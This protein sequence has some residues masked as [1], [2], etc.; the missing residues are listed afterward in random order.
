[1]IEKSSCKRPSCGLLP[2]HIGEYT[3]KVMEC[4][5]LPCPEEWSRMCR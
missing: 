5:T 2:G 1:M 3:L 4:V